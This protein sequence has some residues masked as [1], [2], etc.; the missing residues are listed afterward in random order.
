MRRIRYSIMLMALTLALVGSQPM[1][2]GTDYDLSRNSIDGGGVM[3]STGGGFELS[4]SIGQPD[5]GTMTG[6]GFELAGG[7]W[8]GLAPADC[9]E[10][11]LVSLFDH[12]TFTSCLLGPSG[13]IGAG[14]CPC[15][16]V[17]RDGDITLNDYAQLQA[18]FTGQ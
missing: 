12:E 16:D 18:A 6:G 5:A 11:G 9:N 14:P 17:D 2:G 8:F 4:G 3:R 13:G 15:F 1:M 10:D 7:F